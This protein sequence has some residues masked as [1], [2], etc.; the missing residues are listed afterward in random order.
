MYILQEAGNISSLFL[1]FL[2]P[3]LEHDVPAQLA[4][5]EGIRSNQ[6]RRIAD[7]LYPNIFNGSRSIR[8]SRYL[9]TIQVCS[10][11]RVMCF[12]GFASTTNRDIILLLT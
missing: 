10:K 9:R 4:R 5:R 1:V 2:E 7:R 6:F 11:R 12:T 8:F 3:I